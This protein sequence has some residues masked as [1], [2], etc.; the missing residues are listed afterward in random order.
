MFFFHQN[1]V[2]ARSIERDHFMSPIQAKEFGIID[3]VLAHPMQE[4]AA[5]TAIEKID[6]VTTKP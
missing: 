5:E 6:K 1:H 4:E 2:A 3:K